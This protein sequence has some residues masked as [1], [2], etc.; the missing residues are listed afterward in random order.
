MS[1]MFDS[2]DEGSIESEEVFQD[3]QRLFEKRGRRTF[4]MV[5]QTILDEKVECKEVGEAFRYFATQCWH[6][7]ARPTLLSLCCEA[8]G[9]DPRATKSIAIVMSLISGGIDIHDDIIDQSEVKDGRPT[10]Y[11]K[12]G[13][14][15]ALLVGDALMF[16]GLARLVEFNG[17]IDKEKNAAISRVLKTMFFELG[18]AEAMELRFRRR[19]DIASSDYLNVVRKKA[20]DVE[21]HTYIGGILG[22]GSKKEI[23]ILTRYGRSLG[24]LIILS[25]DN[26]DVVHPEE[27]LH[28][29]QEEHLP[30][31]VL[32][33]L[34]NSK[35]GRDVRSLLDK[36]SLRKAFRM[37]YDSEAFNK[38]EKLMNR[39]SKEALF[40]LE[41]L[42]Y[43]RK[44]LELLVKSTL[45]KKD[46][47][48][49]K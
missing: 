42:R 19:F 39:L 32:Y 35:T 16:K 45:I 1:V 6:D 37:V 27:F 14:D 22:N 11:G 21:A 30:L 33:A 38:V 47:Y 24:M 9:G 29:I 15:I 40:G 25:D 17:E 4:E 8:V 26:A 28:R 41:E 31:P 43:S 5:K 48:F 20:A 46:I 3:L 18:D 34:E 44:E 49:Q 10:V 23:D 7:L 12:F 36:R 13:K 2:G